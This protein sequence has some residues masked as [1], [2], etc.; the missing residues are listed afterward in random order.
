M[1]RSL[2]FCHNDAFPSPLLAAMLSSISAG[3]DTDTAPL[4]WLLKPTSRSTIPAVTNPE[5]VT[6]ISTP[7]GS[8][9]SRWMCVYL[10]TWSSDCLK[11][12]CPHRNVF[13]SSAS[14]ADWWYFMVAFRNNN[15][16]RFPCMLGISFG[17]LLLS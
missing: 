1:N 4:P 11:F 3:I 6:L 17:I 10:T 2:S 9:Q 7:K 12:P 15:V 5:M 13:L 14:F 8:Q 16:N